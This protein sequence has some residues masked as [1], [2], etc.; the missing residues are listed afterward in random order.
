MGKTERRSAAQDCGGGAA[1]MTDVLAG[2]TPLSLATALLAVVMGSV[3]VQWLLSKR[4]PHRQRFAWRGI[5]AAIDII[6]NGR[7]VLQ[8]EAV[9]GGNNHDWQEVYGEHMATDE[10]IDL[11]KVVFADMRAREGPKADKYYP[12]MELID[13]EELANNQALKLGLPGHHVI[14]DEGYFASERRKTPP[15]APTRKV[16]VSHN[17]QD[18]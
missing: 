8:V 14:V 18:V 5:P 15:V 11:L 3:A 4:E 7:E 2:M 9:G 6:A 1:A 13:A 17:P 12:R 10:V 16:T